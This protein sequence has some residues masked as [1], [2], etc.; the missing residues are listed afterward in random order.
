MQMT[1]KNKTN[2][3]A[4][5]TVGIRGDYLRPSMTFQNGIWQFDRNIL[6]GVGHQI[7]S[8]LFLRG[9]ITEC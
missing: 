6:I 9:V 3:R 4:D 2:G 1:K 8:A 5:L 7:A